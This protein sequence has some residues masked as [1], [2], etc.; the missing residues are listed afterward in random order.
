MD[1]SLGPILESLRL[2]SG[3]T[4]AGLTEG[5]AAQE[6]GLA[7]SDVIHAVNGLRI[8]TLDAL[9]AALSQ[10]AAGVHVALQVER[11]GKLLFLAFELP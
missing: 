6:T 9:R 8:E 10:L 2:P 11:A 1:S 3:V 7:A 4:V 5:A